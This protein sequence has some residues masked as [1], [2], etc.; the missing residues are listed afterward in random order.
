MGERRNEYMSV[1]VGLVTKKRQSGRM[2]NDLEFFRESLQVGN[3]VVHFLLCNRVLLLGQTLFLV[4]H[5]VTEGANKII[6]GGGLVIKQPIRFKRTHSACD[7]ILT[8]A[9]DGLGLGTGATLLP[10]GPLTET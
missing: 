3:P 8:F 5:K 9:E 6:F 10:S 2:G 7:R 4:G 1:L